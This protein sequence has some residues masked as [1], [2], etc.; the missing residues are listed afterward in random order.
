MQ[1]PDF[2]KG[3]AM[4]IKEARE[5]A[6]NWVRVHAE[7]LPGYTGAC[8]SGSTVGMPEDAELPPYSDIDIVVFADWNTPPEKPGKFLYR[9]VLLEVTYLPVH[10]IHS[11]EEVL[12][13][14]H[15]AGM[16]RTN[17]LISDPAGDLGRLIDYVSPRFCHKKWVVKRCEHAMDKI[18][19]GL[20][21]LHE[22][23][24][25]HE[26]LTAWLFPAGIMTH[27]L[28]AAALRNPTVRLRYL[29]AREVLE[30]FGL[31]AFYPELLRLQGSE[32][33]TPERVE[34]HTLRL[35]SLFDKAS[36]AART[37]F[38]FS[39]D[40]TSQSRPIAIDGSL[41][42][43]RQGNHRE[44]VFWI[45]A[46]FARC[47]QILAADAPESREA[48]LPDLHALLSDLGF[49]SSGDILRRGEA[50]RAALPSLW[51]AAETIIRHNP[52]VI[53]D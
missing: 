35:A 32:S 51:A 38:F 11:P 40:I 2:D 18:Q 28:L 30:G 1:N 14:Y 26:L 24:P 9:N 31:S 22:Q 10:L 45:A 20:S 16:F 8:F 7:A 23:R 25:I 29:K 49:Q 5:A 47:H 39:S 44:A 6:A 48:Y 36:A 46:T 52:E 15:L 43:I 50:V 37:P 17:T 27:V 13:N 33:L 34:H 42:L 53:Q 3:R 4:R 21:T 12:T 41:E 19:A